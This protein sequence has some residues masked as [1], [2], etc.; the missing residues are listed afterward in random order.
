MTPIGMEPN[1]LRRPRSRRLASAL[2]AL[3]VGSTAALVALEVVFR[4]LP[5]NQGF[6]IEPVQAEHPVLHFEPERCFTWSKGPRFALA[7][8][9]CTN[10]V[11]FRSDRDYVL[12]TSTPLL[13]L[14][15]DS[16]VVAA[17]VPFSETL[18]ARLDRELGDAQ[19][20][21]SFAAP[22]AA[23]PQ[24]LVWAEYAREQFQ[25]DAFVFVVIA[26]DFWG[27]LRPARGF[28]HFVRDTDD[29]ST[30]ARVNY[31]SGWRRRLL[32]H[33][34]LGMYLTLNLQVMNR[35]LGLWREQPVQ[36][37][38]LRRYVGNIAARVPE[39][40]LEEYRWVLRCFLDR[41]PAATGVPYDRMLFV[42]DG[43]RPHMYDPAELAFAETSTW[44]DLRALVLDRAEARGIEVVDLHPLF[45]SQ[46]ES[47]GRRFESRWDNHWNGA[48]HAIA[49]RATASTHTI[50]RVFGSPVPTADDP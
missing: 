3:A 6:V 24:Y 49:A 32:R 4:F 41:L 16:F 2:G 12:D 17:M 43:M 34:A 33:S 31:R 14:I 9:V 40:T 42:L 19:R 37:P 20:V 26:N 38:P 48:G 36:T 10:N 27:S 13:A 8:E 18:G 11:G 22:G 25:P 47:S 39:E 15:G 45:V 28:H 23:F 21:Y 50:R 30:L 46:Y 1:V 29:T 5:V 35:R 7:T 44:A